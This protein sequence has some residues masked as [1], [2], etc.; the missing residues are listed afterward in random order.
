MKSRAKIALNEVVSVLPLGVHNG[1]RIGV[2]APG[3]LWGPSTVTS[4]NPHQKTISHAKQAFNCID[5]R[6]LIEARIRKSDQANSCPCM[7]LHDYFNKHS[8]ELSKLLS[9]TALTCQCL[10]MFHQALPLPPSIIDRHSPRKAVAKNRRFTCWRKKSSLSC[11][12][13][14]WIIHWIYM[15]PCTVYVMYTYAH[16]QVI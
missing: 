12:Y 5:N 3:F 7:I 11:I 14:H 4:T 15:Y 8:D 2:L 10:T 16:P 6:R 13:L 9:L 1:S